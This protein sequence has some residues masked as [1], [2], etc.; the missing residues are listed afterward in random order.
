MTVKRVLATA[1]DS[2]GRAAR[3]G[4][5]GVATNISAADDNNSGEEEHH[6][7]YSYRVP[8]NNITVL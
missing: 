6:N 3:P 2:V 4:V 1:A 8:V 7:N 5:H